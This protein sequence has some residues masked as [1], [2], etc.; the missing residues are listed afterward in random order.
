MAASVNIGGTPESSPTKVSIMLRSYR[1]SRR[2]QP[3][4]NVPAAYLFAVGVPT[5]TRLL[6]RDKR[7]GGRTALV[8]VAGLEAADERRNGAQW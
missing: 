5:D 1:R 4:E 8:C 3:T 2:L 7:T 6:T